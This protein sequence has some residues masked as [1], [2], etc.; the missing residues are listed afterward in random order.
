MRWLSIL[1]LAAALTGCAAGPRAARPDHPEQPAAHQQDD[2]QRISA[3][4]QQ[5]DGLLAEPAA[6]PIA[7]APSPAADVC[8]AACAHQD[9]ICDLTSRI[10]AIADR[11]DLEAEMS[12]QC[13]DARGRCEAARSRVAMRCVCTPP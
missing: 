5:L 9:A 10:C 12:A 1:L 7:P 2:L 13:T 11:N 6:A 8:A 4:E 3:L